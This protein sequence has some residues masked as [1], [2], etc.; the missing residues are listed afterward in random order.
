MRVSDM[1]YAVLLLACD[2]S[3]VGTAGCKSLIRSAFVCLVCVLLCVCG[4]F[5][6][7]CRSVLWLCCVHG[8]VCVWLCVGILTCSAVVLLSWCCLCG[9]RVSDMFHCA[10]ARMRRSLVGMAGRTY[11]LLRSAGP[12][13]CVSVCVVV[14]AW[15][16]SCVFSQCVMVVL[17]AWC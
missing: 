13:V 1:F 16:A 2:A 15:C 10:L 14:F 17:R 11:S 8:A 5:L 9:G 6:A 12:C 7:C 3:L 4:V